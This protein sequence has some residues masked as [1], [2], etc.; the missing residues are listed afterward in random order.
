MYSKYLKRIIDFLFAL[1]VTPIVMFVCA[2]FGFLIWLEDRGAIFYFAKRRGKEG[3]I[4]NMYKLRSMK[5][6][7]PDIRN[8]DNSTYNSANDIRVTRIGAFL[9]RTSIDELP[10]FFNV[11]KGNMSII[12]PRPITIDRPLENYDKKRLDRLKVRPGITGYTQAYYRNNISQEEK[13]Q[14]DADYAQQVTF[15]LD[16]KIIIQ[17]VK[18]VLTKK[19]IFTN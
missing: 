16:A 3:V 1:L 17:T 15:W 10:Q 12:G 2:I 5:M 11:L 14:L 8:D 19:G 9:R 13:L 7:A 6:N 18:T 4:F